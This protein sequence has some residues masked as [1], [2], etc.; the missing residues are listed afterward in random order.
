[1]RKDE[2]L[3]TLYALESLEVRARIPAPFQAELTAALQV[4]AQLPATASVG[5]QRLDLT[6]ER[7]AG[8]ASASGIDALFAIADSNADLVRAGQ[9]VA[10][11]LE[12]PARE[13]AVAVPFGAVYGGNRVYTLVDGRMKGIPVR[14]LGGWLTERGE[15][16]L[17]VEATALATGDRLIITH[18]PNAVD[19]LRVE[20]IP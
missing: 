4:H 18:M 19:G 9:L 15:E 3:L 5:E 17:L 6:L 13:D 1:M 7:L 12:R 2:V 11:R 14:P 10:V 20:S 16:R 8:E